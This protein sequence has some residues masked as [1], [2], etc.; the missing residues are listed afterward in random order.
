[1]RSKTS[2]K[3]GMPLGFLLQEGVHD[4]NKPNCHLVSATHTSCIFNSAAEPVRD[5]LLHP[6]LLFVL[7]TLGRALQG[8]AWPMTGSLVARTG[9]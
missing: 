5:G 3:G 2:Q 8:W 7:Q 9:D 1:M 4:P 6:L